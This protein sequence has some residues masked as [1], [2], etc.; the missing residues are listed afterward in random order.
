MSNL[1]R[2]QGPRTHVVPFGVMLAE[3]LAAHDAAI[4]REQRAAVVT[5]ARRRSP[6]PDPDC[7]HPMLSALRSAGTV[8]DCA[9]HYG[10][11]P[12]CDDYFVV[13]EW[14]NG[15]LESRPMTAA[16]QDTFAVAD[17]RAQRDEWIAELQ[18][19]AL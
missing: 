3:R 1:L 9:T 6:L 13:T 5:V 2:R 14:A 7:T 16:E 11:C 12:E 15:A 19:G 18:D 8:G 10:Y 17:D 4:V